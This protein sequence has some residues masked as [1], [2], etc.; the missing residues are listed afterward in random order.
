MCILMADNMCTSLLSLQKSSLA[1]ENEDDH[2][3]EAE[4]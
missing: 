2:Y 3:D 1:D 4:V